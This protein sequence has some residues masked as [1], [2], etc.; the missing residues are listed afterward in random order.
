MSSRNWQVVKRIMATARSL[1]PIGAQEGTEIEAWFDEYGRQHVVALDGLQIA[2]G[3]ANDWLHVHKFGAA[4]DFDTADGEVTIWDGADDDEAWE[5]MKYV[6]STGADI[7]S[8]SSTDDGDTQDIEIQGLD[9]NYA[10]VTQTATLTG[11]T[12][13]ALATPLFR[14]FRAKN[15]GSVDLAG[16]AIIY[17]NDTQVAVPG[18]PD[19][20][21]LIRAVIHPGNNQTEMA[22]Y[23]VPAGY[24]AFIYSFAASTA[25][26]SKD[27]NY[28]IRLY[29][30]PFGQVFQLKHRHS[31]SDTGSSDF[32]H[33]HN[34]PE[35]FCEKADI[36]M[37]VQMT[38]VGASEAA[39]SGS[40]VIVLIPN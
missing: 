8:I 3:L 39:I 2:R 10:L 15:V 4:F 16:H 27:S 29:C 14:V 6:Y 23:T 18:V 12:R 38:A 21:T 13:K 19:D 17:E 11:Q 40:F 24:A 1:V 32:E 7:D 26:A 30:R 25:G 37:T 36:E 9:A 20:P 28:I 5:L 31:I 22:L 34:I 33:S 35:E